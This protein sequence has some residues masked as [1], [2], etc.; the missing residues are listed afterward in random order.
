MTSELEQRI[1]E[2]VEAGLYTSASEVVRESLRLL[3]EVEELRERRRARLQHDILLG[4]TQLHRGE[5]V[6][7]EHVFAELTARL[8]GRR[9]P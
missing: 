8:E 6:A 5:G 9:K 4:V 7:S 3:F 1:A 2:K